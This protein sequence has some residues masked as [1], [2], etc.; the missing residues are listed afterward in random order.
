MRELPLHKG[1]CARQIVSI[2]LSRVATDRNHL[3]IRVLLPPLSMIPVYKMHHHAL[4]LLVAG[5]LLSCGDSTSAGVTLEQTSAS[6]RP[7]GHLLVD[8]PNSAQQHEPLLRSAKRVYNAGDERMLFPG[9]EMVVHQLE[10]TSLKADKSMWSKGWTRLKKIVRGSHGQLQFGDDVV[11]TLQNLNKE[12]LSR[13]YKVPHKS[14]KVSLLEAL[15]VR[16]GIG[17][18]ANALAAVKQGPK[19]AVDEGIVDNLYMEQIKK[20][21]SEGKLASDVA[22]TLGIEHDHVLTQKLK[23]VEDYINSIDEESG[24]ENHLLEAV[25]TVLGGENNVALFIGEARMKSVATSEAEKLEGLL[26]QKWLDENMHPTD[27]LTRLKID[28]SA[29]DLMSP[30]LETVV[31]YVAAFNTKN[32]GSE[33]SLFVHARKLY[34]DE[35]LVNAVIAARHEYG[36]SS[37]A[38]IAEQWQNLLLKDWHAHKKTIPDVVKLLIYDQEE[39]LALRLEACE[40][41]IKLS[42]TGT[43]GDDILLESLMTVLDGEKG[44]ASFVGK[45]KMNVETKNVAEKVEGLLIQKWLDKN[46]HPMELLERLEMDGEFAEYLM[47]PMLETVVK[48]V[49]A[50]NTKNPGSEF[51]LFVHA[52]KLYK[53]EPLVDAVIAARH[54][55]GGSSIAK[56]AEQ[57][58]NL[59]LKDWHA[60]KKTIPDVVKLLIYDQE[61]ALALRLEACEEYIKLSKTGTSGDDILPE[62]LMT[63]LD[64]EKGVAS[65]V[66]KAKMKVET[67]NGAEKVEGLLIQKW[68][69]KNMH[70]MELLERLEMDGEFAEYLMS[71]MLETVVK[72]V[73]AFN[74]KNPGSEFSLFVHA[75]K[76]YKDEPLVN[77]VIAARHEYGGSSI[78]KIAEQWQNL[79]LK[80]WHAHKKTIPDVVKL[81]IYDQEEALALRLE[82]CEEYIKLSKTGTSGDDILLESL[83]TV[84]DG[85]KGVASFV[86][87][88]KMK[89]ETKNGAEKVEGLLIQKW[90]DKNMH[91]MDLLERLE[92]DGEFAEYL[93][94]PMLET[95]VK[96]VAAFNTKNP[97]SEFL[98]F[99]HTRKLY[100]DELLVN[101][102]IAARRKYLGSFTA[103][104][105]EQWQNLLLKDWLDEDKSVDEVA[106]FLQLH[107]V[108][109]AK[110]LVEKRLEVLSDYVKLCNEK[111]LRQ[112]TDLSSGTQSGGGDIAFAVW[113]SKAMD[114]MT[115]K[116]SSL[117]RYRKEL[118]TR[119]NKANV[120]LPTLRDQ[121]SNVEKKRFGPRGIDLES[122]RD[123]FALQKAKKAS[124]G[125]ALRCLDSFERSVEL[126]LSQQLSQHFPY[127]VNVSRR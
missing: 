117:E 114:G 27:L 58:Q 43:S 92:M 119:W 99:V 74:T 95:V 28:K 108:R 16:Y 6:F 37:I 70:P 1:T 87:K 40:E 84:L 61:E 121:L 19:S 120:F 65:F 52:R 39:A 17:P 127:I 55:Y 85:E 7:Q 76:L 103:G 101:A 93:M 56:I 8:N 11:M 12:A 14:E 86:G 88:A 9:G 59:L 97:G 69:D 94:S 109:F 105:A 63:V 34:K 47:S 10:A 48:Y 25:T 96:Y 80:D 62:S 31:K 90:L 100:K 110:P 77:A 53:D 32:P 106:V 83:M 46:M 22:G 42:K 104:I 33:F 18:V 113:L 15:T 64:G 51:S 20:W 66:G 72:Y 49:A 26:I 41:Y 54:E 78:A 35:L 23:M 2:G 124:E 115:I 45:A 125:K 82:A 89:V 3:T 116:P 71:P 29:E 30:M 4:A 57:W 79:L 73:A 68:L 123:V 67:K 38:K 122:V 118:F 91:P 102:V 126:L 36:G 60:H 5:L 50:F 13:K 98:L 107:G 81:L 44:V 21:R 112:D 75:R 111:S 24:I